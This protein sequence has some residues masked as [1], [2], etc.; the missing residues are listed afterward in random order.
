MPGKLGFAR[1]VNVGA[2]VFDLIPPVGLRVAR[3]TL[4]FTQPR[5]DALIRIDAV[6]IRFRRV[7]RLRR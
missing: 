1:I 7:C 5:D 2:I 6:A 3:A 4:F